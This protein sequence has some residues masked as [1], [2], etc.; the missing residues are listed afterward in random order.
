MLID[1]VSHAALPD[2]DP[3]AVNLY[4]NAQNL[5]PI[6]HIQSLNFCFAF[7]KAGVATSCLN[8]PLGFCLTDNEN[9]AVADSINHRI[10]VKFSEAFKH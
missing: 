7:G 9:I 6:R 1:V 4:F 10:Q 3:A 2:P 8:T 5:K